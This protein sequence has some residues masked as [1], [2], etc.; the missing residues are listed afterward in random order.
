MSDTS[1]RFG[2]GGAD[3]P[4]S[5][6]W[7]LWSLPK[8]S[9][10]YLSARAVAGVVK[11]SIHG[12]GVCQFGLT[13]AYAASQGIDSTKRLWERWTMPKSSGGPSIPLRLLFPV[14]SLRDGL[15]SRG[16]PGKP[17]YWAEPVAGADAVEFALVFLDAPVASDDWPGRKA[18]GSTR[19][20]S[21]D[22]PDGRQFWLVAYPMNFTPE[23]VAGLEE[24]KAKVRGWTKPA[25]TD[26]AG[27]RGFFLADGPAGGRVLI[28][29]AGD[30]VWT[31]PEA[32]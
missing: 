25:V 24:D 5:A 30:E 1:F 3:Q 17:L 9:D 10:V 14:A 21:A 12:S 13:S 27:V 26:L 15:P 20:V 16:T 32:E 23:D 31:H 29:F 6:I 2:V 18:P 22:L 8:K 19:I 11:V 28:E 4:R 7:R